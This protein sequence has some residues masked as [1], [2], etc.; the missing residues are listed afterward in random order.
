MKQ[1]YRFIS[2]VLALGNGTDIGWELENDDS[3]EL[4]LRNTSPARVQR[5]LQC[6]D[7]RIQFVCLRRIHWNSR[8]VTTVQ[9]SNE[10]Y[11]HWKK[12][13]FGME[14]WRDCRFLWEHRLVI[15]TNVT[16]QRNEAK[17]YNQRIE[18]RNSAKVENPVWAFQPIESFV[19]L[20][21]SLIKPSQSH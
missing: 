9:L 17:K 21:E 5:P 3:L 15:G 8:K 2:I 19:K 18:E 7:H 12:S 11:V 16:A 10:Q 1:V 6:Y 13:Q 4:S 20:E 14:V